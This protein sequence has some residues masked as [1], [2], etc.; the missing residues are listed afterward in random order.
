M[1]QI[2]QPLVAILAGATFGIALAE[3]GKKVRKRL[4]R[5]KVPPR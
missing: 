4:V 2:A 1:D 3:A 5:V